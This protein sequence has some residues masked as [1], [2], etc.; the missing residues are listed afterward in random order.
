VTSASID[1]Q[2]TIP[3]E[4][5]EIPHISRTGFYP[6]LG[7]LSCKVWLLVLLAP[8]V[9]L[10][11]PAVLQLPFRSI[12]SLILVEAKVNGCRA[13]LVLDTGANRTILNA[14]SYGNVKVSAVRQ[15]KNNAGIIGE[16]LRLRVQLE[17]GHQY[18]FS[19]PVS[20]MNIDDL[21]RQLGIQFDGL[22]GQDILREFRFMRI[23]YKTHVIE[24]EK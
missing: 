18:L 22:L 14:K 1:G 9:G 2:A 8:Q 17:L 5:H 4:G 19:Q 7:R 23:D 20:V 12:N 21:A 13:T 6:L 11:E 3:A 16:S 15:A 10:A 24:L